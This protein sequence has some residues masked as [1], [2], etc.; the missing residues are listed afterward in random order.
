MIPRVTL[1]SPSALAPLGRST[2]QVV[3]TVIGCGKLVI[4]SRGWA[5]VSIIS[6]KSVIDKI[7]S[8]GHS[9]YEA[10]RWLATVTGK[11]SVQS[12]RE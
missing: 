12:V 4:I 2:F 8:G 5:A 3:L 7:I 10:G 11:L 1:R 6:V 9:L